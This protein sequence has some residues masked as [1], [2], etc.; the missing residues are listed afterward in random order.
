M[1]RDVTH[2]TKCVTCNGSSGQW[3]GTVQRHQERRDDAEAGRLAGTWANCAAK[4]LGD[5]QACVQIV[6][7]SMDSVASSE[8]AA[9]PAALR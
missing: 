5:G 9:V 6:G 3:E 7:S 2:Y 1:P 8:F 4:G